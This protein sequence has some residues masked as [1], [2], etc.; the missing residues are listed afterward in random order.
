LKK[1]GF[2]DDMV[3]LANTL[4]PIKK[5]ILK[6]E[7][8]TTNLADCYFSFLKIGVA[9]NSISDNNYLMFKNHCINCF[10]KR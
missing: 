1:R 6:V 2:F 4:L 9:I 7:N 8:R 10:N 5:A 3:H